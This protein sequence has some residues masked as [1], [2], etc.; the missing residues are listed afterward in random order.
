M[1]KGT[2]GVVVDFSSSPAVVGSRVYVAAAQGSFF[3]SG[4][5]VYCLDADSGVDLW[6]Y[7]MP[8]Q[9][10]SSPAVAGGRVYVGEGFHQDAD[11]HLY[12]LDADS[13]RVIWQFQTASHV[14]STPIVSQ[15]KVYFGAGDD[16]VY[17]VDALEGK[18]IWHYPFGHV[19]VSPVIWKGKVYFGTGYGGYRIHAV[20]ANTG[21]KGLVKTGEVSRLGESKCARRYGLFRTRKR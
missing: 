16:G 15:G 1:F 21:E 12:C 19:D 10:F 5:V 2:G 8:L 6:R 18:Q 13:G 14:E 3:S 17:C 9:V 7:D 20:D 11:C 4:G